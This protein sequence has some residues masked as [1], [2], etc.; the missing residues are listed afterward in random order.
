MM[1]VIIG[2]MNFIVRSVIVIACLWIGFMNLGVAVGCGYSPE[3]TIE[4]TRDSRFGAQMMSFTCALSAAEPYIYVTDYSLGPTIP[5]LMKQQSTLVVDILVDCRGG[6]IGHWKY[7][8]TN[9][10]RDVLVVLILPQCWER[11]PSD[12]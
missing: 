1:T 7:A 8:I 5:S 10:L 4:R 2:A 12:W 6:T 9:A 3:S 11:C